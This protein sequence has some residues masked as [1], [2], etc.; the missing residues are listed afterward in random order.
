MR[1]FKVRHRRRH[2]ELVSERAETPEQAIEQGL[3][4]LRRFYGRGISR[5]DVEA[6]DVTDQPEPEDPFGKGDDGEAL[7]RSVRSGR[8]P[9]EMAG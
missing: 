7:M 1:Y 9:S 3:P 5:S 6:I 4:D 2:N 8:G